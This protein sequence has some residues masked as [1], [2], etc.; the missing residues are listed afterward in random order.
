VPASYIDPVIASR[1]RAAW[2]NLAPDVRTRIT[3]RLNAKRVAKGF[4]QP[5]PLQELVT[6]DAAVGAVAV[7]KVA[8]TSQVD[9]SGEIWG[10]GRYEHLDP[11]WAE[12]IACWLETMHDH[13]PFNTA[14]QVIQI[15]DTVK[16]AIAGDWGCGDWRDAGNPAPSTRVAAQMAA[17]KPDLTVHLGDEYYAGTADEEKHLFAALWPQGRLGSFAMQS[18]HGMY[19][20]GYG[21]YDVTLDHPAFR[22]QRG[23]SFFALENSNWVIVGLD[24]AYYADPEGLYMDGTL[25]GNG[26]PDFQSEFLREQVAKGKKAVVLTHHNGLSDDGMTLND[27]GAQVMSFTARL[28]V[29]TSYWYWGHSHFAAVY[30][31][32]GAE[33]FCRCVGHGG[34]PYGVASV[35]ESSAVEWYEKRL[36]N[37]PEIPQRVMNGFCQ[38]A[39]DGPNIVETFYDEQGGIAWQ[40][41]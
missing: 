5:V 34:V 30:K 15:P 23:C 25:R 3:A 28:P 9:S 37:D 16:I 14:A 4:Q 7:P 39:L 17:L 22:L 32:D 1:I 33:P 35:L 31:Q 18:N 13:H 24:S 6:L 12:S 11:G 21:Y 29:Q 27:F 10:T 36:A 38:V 2:G 19:S 20:G 41:K 40:S 8:L 26:Y